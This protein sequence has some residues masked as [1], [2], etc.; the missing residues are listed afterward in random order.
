MQWLHKEIIGPNKITIISYQHLGIRTVFEK[1]NFGRKKLV[2]EV[3]HRYCTQ[4]IAQNV[5]M[6][7]RM[8]RVT[9]L[10]K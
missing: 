10:F 5:Y 1:S 8:K 9:D 4:H 2:G 3:V 7:C 6:D